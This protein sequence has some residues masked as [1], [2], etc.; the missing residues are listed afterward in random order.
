MVQ[1]K[2]NALDHLTIQIRIEIILAP[3]LSHQ[4]MPR[5]KK[6]RPST[7]Y[8]FDPRVHMKIGMSLNPAS[9]L[10][11]HHQQTI[12]AMR[13]RNP[14]IVLHFIYADTL[15]HAS[16]KQALLAWSQKYRI[17]LHA[18]ESLRLPTYHQKIQPLSDEARKLDIHLWVLIRQWLN[19]H[20]THPL[21]PS[22][23]RIINLLLRVMLTPYFGTY[24]DLTMS[25]SLDKHFA[26]NKS[27][28]FKKIKTKSPILLPISEQRN[29]TNIALDCCLF[30][31]NSPLNENTQN[32]LFHIKKTMLSSIVSG[33]TWQE[34]FTKNKQED[35]DWALLNLLSKPTELSLIELLDDIRFDDKKLISF[36]RHTLVIK[37]PKQ[38]HR[39]HAWPAQEV[40]HAVFDDL[41][42]KKEPKHLDIFSIEMIKLADCLAYYRQ[43]LSRLESLLLRVMV[44]RYR[45]TSALVAYIT[46]DT[47]KRLTPNV[48]TWMRHASFFSIRPCCAMLLPLIHQPNPWSH[49]TPTTQ[50][51]HIA[52]DH[53][54]T[55]IGQ[56]IQHHQAIRLLEATKKLQRTYRRHKAPRI[57]NTPLPIAS[58]S[59]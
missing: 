27:G 58:L 42:H 51:H 24:S 1:G 44:G 56:Y 39:I 15:L 21:Q 18:I 23:L 6:K 35:E 48:L 43:R 14:S 3:L 54:W 40:I 41:L 10:P 8:F 55:T 32:I 13:V 34:I 31:V 12:L 38:C 46:A 22:H 33:K 36:L 53:T 59:S 25:L 45:W 5:R 30:A 49:T 29:P 52:S 4:T 17:T 7:D 37:S 47:S 50:L 28:N 57:L 20:H 11:M 9:F 19:R 26:K 2:V 16:A